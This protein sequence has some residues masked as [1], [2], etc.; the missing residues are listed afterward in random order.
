MSDNRLYNTY[1]KPNLP[2]SKKAW[3]ILIAIVIVSIFV[4][5]WGLNQLIKMQYNVQLLSNPCAMC[6]SM[7]NKCQVSMMINLTN[8]S[9]AEVCD[10]GS[11][12]CQSK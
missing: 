10:E 3:V 12:L 7:G 4:L 2:E 6:E 9:I 1:I 5:A 8:L 11:N